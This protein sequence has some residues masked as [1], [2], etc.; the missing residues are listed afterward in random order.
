MSSDTQTITF[1]TG[2]N[3]GIGLALARLL[4]SDAS[5]TVLLG[6]R[7]LEKG[8]A[9]LENLNALGLP[10]TADVVQLDVTSEQS[11]AEAAKQHEGSL[12]ERISSTVQTNVT[13]P[14]ITFEAFTPLLSKSTKTPR[15]IN[16][17]SNTGSITLRLDPSYPSSNHEVVPYRISKAALNMLTACQAY[18][19]GPL[20][21]KIFAFDPGHTESNL[22]PATT[23]EYGAKPTSEGARPMLDILAG[24]R[25]AEHAGFL[26]GLPERQ[27][28]W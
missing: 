12:S 8:R 11:V 2:A 4:L 23:A 21:W 13:G 3:G 15:I 25:D 22:S 6:S 16:V 26:N 28:P 14:A 18:K 10:G 1:I 19:Y 7:S 5:N 17:S 20:G 27:H 24:E 9:A